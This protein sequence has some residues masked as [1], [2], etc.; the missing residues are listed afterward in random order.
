MQKHLLFLLV[1][2]S[3]H[4]VSSFH[5][6]SWSQLKPTWWTSQKTP[7]PV[8]PAS[9]QAQEEQLDTQKYLQIGGLTVGG[10]MTLSQLHRCL[11][12]ASAG[13]GAYLLT[14]FAFCAINKP[15]FARACLAGAMGT[16]G[17]LAYFAHYDRTYIETAYLMGGFGISAASLYPYAQPHWQKFQEKLQQIKDWIKENPG[18]TALMG[19][20]IVVI[21][22]FIWKWLHGQ[23]TEQDFSNL[24]GIAN[25]HVPTA[26]T[27][28]PTHINI[29]LSPAVATPQV[30]VTAT[31]TIP[32]TASTSDIFSAK[33]IQGV[34][35]ASLLVGAAAAAHRTTKKHVQYAAQ[36]IA[37]FEVKLNNQ[38][39][40]KL[41]I[42]PQGN[43]SSDNPAIMQAIVATRRA[44][45]PFKV[46]LRTAHPTHRLILQRTTEGLMVIIATPGPERKHIDSVLIPTVQPLTAAIT[47]KLDSLVAL[48]LL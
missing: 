37:T 29:T 8:A 30:E 39:E 34:A 16:I 22:T 15:S 41:F 43:F 21:G 12:A 44:D 32:T 28:Q 11:I 31:P 10:L 1:L 18:K 46:V 9:A 17:T 26:Q 7:S 48:T 20:S 3:I 36:P 19:G 40:G 6:F 2:I 27:A 4:Q 5:A 35:G 38:Q 24:Q 13:T 42:Y 45:Q 33:N 25:A 23:A 47:D 14:D